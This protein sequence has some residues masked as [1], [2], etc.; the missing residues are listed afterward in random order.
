MAVHGSASGKQF[1]RRT[2]VGA[3]AA[4]MAAGATG[5]G[6]QP[7]SARVRSAKGRSGHRVAVLGG[8][9]AG[10]SA[11]HELA[12]HGFDVAVY[13]RKAFGGKAR[14]I[15]VAGT[16]R[17]GRADLPGEHGFRFFPGFYRNL[18]DTMARIPFGT[19]SR[20]VL[21]NLHP[22]PSGGVSYRGH[23]A[24][25]PISAASDPGT[26]TPDA[27]TE[28]L[29]HLIGFLPVSPP[30]QDVARFVDKIVAWHTSGPKRR[31]G[32][33]ER[34][35]FAEAVGADKMT[36]TG[37]DMLVS[38]P[39]SAFVA[40]R[41][42]LMS[43]Y[44][45]GLMWE[46]LLLS[47]M[48]RGGYAD[49]D[50]VLDAP[51]NEAWIDPWLRHLRKLGV[52]LHLHRTVTELHY[53]GGR[54]TAAEATTPSGAR[55]PIEADWYVLAVPVERAVGLLKGEVL[56]ADPGLGGLSEL[57]TGWMNGLQLFTETELDLPKGHSIFA[58]QPWSLTGIPQSRFWQ[59][60]FAGRYGDGGAVAAFSVDISEWDRPGIRFGKTARQCTRDEILA[61]VLAQIRAAMH[62][63][64]RRL[65]DSAIRAWTLDPA[66]TGSATSDVAND[67]PLFL[68]TPSS[69]R[70]RPD[71]VT[72]IGNL[73]LAA[74]YVH[75]DVNLATMEGANE[76]ART[77]VNGILAAAGE[78]SRVP[79]RR[80]YRP[81]EFKSL[82]DI[83]DHR[84]ERGLPNRFEVI[85]PT[86]PR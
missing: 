41:P 32:Q 26:L 70:H 52:R 2:F 43:T 19:N 78:R 40:T 63:G 53:A 3:T 46:A 39:T 59:S 86:P 13:E 4:A 69:L 66:I 16:G 85:D 30:P 27:L 75:T 29:T 6:A 83:D 54:I 67:E 11:A 8:G 58:G 61:E 65:P 21:D 50:R 20:G 25:L 73:F 24:T 82:W 15:P 9:V 28:M 64:N 56:A 48:G 7:R 84:Y 60:G 17:G 23:D 81:P 38:V 55:E 12:E 37:R 42:E 80:L 76:A 34:I 18:D 71:A 62:D 77:A 31:L 33:W 44:T 35:A 5:A 68:S 49:V 57:R 74:D 14:S 10:L 36:R 47:A 79:V 51:T 72:R 22:T 45:G 1:P